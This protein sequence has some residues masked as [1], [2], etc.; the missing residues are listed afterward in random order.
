MKKAGII[1]NDYNIGI[2]WII[3]TPVLSEKDKN[4]KEISN[5]QRGYLQIFLPPMVALI[6]TLGL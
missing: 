3:K 1:W 4:W 2:K 5:L 6:L